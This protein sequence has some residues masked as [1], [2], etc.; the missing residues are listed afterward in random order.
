MTAMFNTLLAAVLLAVG[1]LWFKYQRQDGLPLYPH[2]KD[3][4]ARAPAT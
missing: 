4:P 2:R 3:R 1:V